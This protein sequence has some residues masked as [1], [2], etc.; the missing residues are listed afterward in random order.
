MSLDKFGRSSHR[1][2]SRK[3]Q[4]STP[5]FPLTADGDFDFYNR[6]LCNVGAPLSDSDSANKE[7]VDI[8]INDVNDKIKINT[9]EFGKLGLN[10]YQ[11]KGETNNRMNNCSKIQDEFIQKIDTKFEDLKKE[12]MR[13]NL[14]FS[15]LSME[16][17]KKEEVDAH[18]KSQ[19]D[20]L[21]TLQNKI[22]EALDKLNK[23]IKYLDGKIHK[24]E[25]S[26]GSRA[27]QTS[28]QKFPPEKNNN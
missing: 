21:L 27:T 11:F 1:S 7:Y 17:Y 24:G 13:V 8:Q 20:K 19:E 26:S 6:K 10:Y 18:L 25:N 15:S 23:K 3:I 5:I 2:K 12:F 4:S 14:I 28:T 9:A 16:Y 22:I